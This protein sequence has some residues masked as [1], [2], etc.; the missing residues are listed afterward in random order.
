M[1]GAWEWGAKVKTERARLKL[2][3]LAGP[4]GKRG[5]SMVEFAL[6][7][8][9]LFILIFGILQVGLIYW[10]SYELYNATLAAAR[11]IRTGEAQT[12][13]WDQAYVAGEICKRTSILSNCTSKLRLSVQ[14]FTNFAAVT[15]PAPLDA[16]G[17]LKTSFPYLPS[18]S[19]TVNLVTAFYEWPLVNFAALGLLANIADN[20]RLLQSSA[21]FKTEPFG[22]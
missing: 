10:G 4:R 7:A 15:A 14:N 21:V 17:A 11:T 22:G 12:K 13:N 3:I 16:N 18:V 19:S 1:N 2:R 20:N 9:P 5:A 8:L 6:I